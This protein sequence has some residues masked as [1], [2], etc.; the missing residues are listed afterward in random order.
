MNSINSRNSKDIDSKIIEYGLLFLI[1]FTPLPFASVWDWSILVIQ[2][3]ILVMTF[4]YVLM[5]NKPVIESSFQD[6][7]KRAKIL[8][9]LFFS[10]LLLQI[11]PLP[12]FLIKFLSPS[13]YSLQQLLAID[14]SSKK[15]LS[16]SALP[17][18]SIQKG[19][20]LFSYFLLGFLIVKT[21]TKLRKIYKFLYLIVIMGVAEAFYGLFEFSRK[22]PHILFYPKKYNLDCVTGTFVNRDHFAGYLEMIIPLTIGLILAKIE[23]FS[24]R[25][26]SLKEKILYL[27][28]KNAL[29]N[30]ILT[31]GVIVMSIA[32]IFTKSRSGIVIL[33][34]SFIL[35]FLLTVYFREKIKMRRVWSRNF[36]K[37][38]F[39]FII[40]LSLFIGINQ[41]LI[42]FSP[43]DISQEGRYVTWSNTG[44]IIKD[45]FLWGTGLGT[46]SSMYPV[47]EVI[48]TPGFLSHA[49]NDYLEFFSE[50]GII[51]FSLL[52]I[53]LGYL[54][55]R[56]SKT[57]ASRFHPEMKGI[58]LGG[59]TAIVAIFIH[60]LADFNLQIP[61]N[62]V[63]FTI[64]F[65]LT[66]VTVFYRKS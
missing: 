5:K 2:L 59:I 33:I 8:F 48:D 16:L 46:F 56:I 13:N 7:I 21:I 6:T 47:Y 42:R 25:E 22:T 27:S 66:L 45:F 19:L 10:Y 54:F 36:L 20:L 65:A 28:Q 41:I 26:K 55:Y 62:A 3:V 53:C 32:L 51:G 61:A 57:W 50:L 9:I 49:H 17:Y 12:K 18:A 30:I 4:S 40:I 60:S 58:G 38:T 34:F 39:S 52:L 1:V 14:F 43:E 29:K 63:L 24:P 31:G 23:F 15:F 37:V 35:M 44:L 64:I 11:I